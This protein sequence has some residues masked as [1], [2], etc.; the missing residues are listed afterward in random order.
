LVKIAIDIKIT[1][2]TLCDV[3]PYSMMEVFRRF[4]GTLYHHIHR[5]RALMMMVA[6]SSETSVKF[7]SG[8]T[9]PHS[10]NKISSAT[11]VRTLDLP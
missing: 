2:C 1:D 5:R 8:Y 7:L 6:S 3:V 11:T 4:G 10:K 9:A